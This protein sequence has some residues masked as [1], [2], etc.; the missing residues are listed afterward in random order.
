IAVGNEG[1]GGGGVVRIEADSI[2]L[3]NTGNIT[4]AT[5][6][7]EGGDIFLNSRNLQLRNGSSISATAG[8]AGGGGNG[9]NIII[10]TDSLAAVNRS[11]ITTNA[12]TGRGGNIQITTQGIF[13]SPDSIFDASS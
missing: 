8:L 12:F 4:A 1:R 6:S 11:S 5:A 10:D 2:N 9:G 3:D 7:G 13:Q